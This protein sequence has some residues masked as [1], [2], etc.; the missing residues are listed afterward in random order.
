VRNYQARN[1]MRDDMRVGDLVLFH[2][3]G[4][5]TPG[6]AGVA[7]VCSKPHADATALDRRSQYF[8]PKATRDEPIWMCVDIAFVK[9]FPRVLTLKELKADSR[10]KGMVLLKTG[11]RLSVQ[12]VTGAQFA[13]VSELAAR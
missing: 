13:I 10:L 11:S 12:P 6:I 4:G 8:D 3:S 2:H 9:K 1:F 7:K 5:D